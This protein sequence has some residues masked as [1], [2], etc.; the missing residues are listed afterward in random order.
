MHSVAM[1]MPPVMKGLESQSALVSVQYL[2]NKLCELRARF[3]FQREMSYCYIICLTET[4][5]LKAMPDNAIC[6]ETVDRLTGQINYWEKPVEE[7]CG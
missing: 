7:A 6:V 5:L 1:E 4:W 2:D 3:S